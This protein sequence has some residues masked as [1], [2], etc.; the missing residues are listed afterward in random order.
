MP[1]RHLLPRVAGSA[2]LLLWASAAAAQTP[3]RAAAPDGLWTRSSLL[4]D[5]GGL[6]AQLARAGLS[7][8]LQETSEVFANLTGGVHRGAAYDGVTELGL[9][10]DTRRAFGWP[11]GTI[12]VSALADPRPQPERGQSRQPPDRQRHRGIAFD[13]VVGAVVP[14]G[15]L[16]RPGGR[17]ARPA[18]HR[19]GVHDQP[20]LQPVHQHDDGLADAA[21]GG[22]LRRRAGLSAVLARRA[23]AGAPDRGAHRA[24]RRVRRQP[25][26]R[27]VRQ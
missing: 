25:A 11:G 17:E 9:G 14:A 2:A 21:L 23:A 15:L 13:P 3:P 6:R 24:R 22:S 20:G 16:R 26:G 5:P 8:G 4:G 7:L 19:P 1:R 12:N 18:E 27:A 10:I